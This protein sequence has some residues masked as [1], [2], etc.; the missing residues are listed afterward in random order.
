MP[1]PQFLG[2]AF[3]L[4][5]YPLY[6]KRKLE[7]TNRT[8]LFGFSLTI[9][10]SVF[11][12]GL[13]FTTK[14]FGKY[15]SSLDLKDRDF[16]EMGCGSGLL[17]LIAAAKGAMVTSVDINAIAVECTRRNADSNGLG[18]RIRTIKSDLFECVDND[19]R[20]DL[21]IWNPPFFPQESSD[22]T[23]KAWKAGEG[24]RVFGRFADEATRYLTPTGT[25]LLLLTDKNVDGDQ[26]LSFFLKKG[27]VSRPVLVRTSLFETFTIFELIIP[28]KTISQQ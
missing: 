13:F 25:V 1:L 27:F 26:I 5:A 4:V 12:P 3:F 20:F 18:Q 10:P 9:P 24:Y 17:S 19:H 16:L 14:I 28:S 22:D 6:Y 8:R 7:K 21:I 15:I 11:H 2:R 23:G